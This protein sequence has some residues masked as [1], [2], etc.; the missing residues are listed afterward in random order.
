MLRIGNG[1]APSRDQGARR[2]GRRGLANQQ[3]QSLRG[4]GSCVRD[5][6]GG[7]SLRAAP[8]DGL[9]PGLRIDLSCRRS[10]ALNILDGRSSPWR[11]W[12]QIGNS[13]ANATATRLQREQV[14]RR[15]KWAPDQWFSTSTQCHANAARQTHDLGSTP[16]SP[17]PYRDILSDR[18]LTLKRNETLIWRCTRRTKKQVVF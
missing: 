16:R 8:D 9:D 7:G 13:T 2:A 11:I 15:R 10:R 4:G 18:S 3:G 1:S 14:Q 17:V 12:Q 5:W 6:S